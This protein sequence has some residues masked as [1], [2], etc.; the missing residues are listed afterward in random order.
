MVRKIGESPSFKKYGAQ[1]H[2]EPFPLC[3]RFEPET[4]LYWACY[5]KS[6]TTTDHHPVGT[7]KMGPQG[8]KFVSKK[9]QTWADSK[10][11][12]SNLVLTPLWKALNRKPSQ[13]LKASSKYDLMSVVDPDGLKVHGVTNLRVVDASVMPTVPSGNINIPIVMVA[14][15]A[16]DL[17][18]K[19]YHKLI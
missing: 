14:E 5:V 11:W 6:M 15:K 9:G 19:D 13:K 2:E 10:G 16:A 12:T 4:D 8:Q 17:V 1:F 7:C 3:T 18:K